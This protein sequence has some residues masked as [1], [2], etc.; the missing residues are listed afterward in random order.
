MKKILL[1]LFS[2]L[3]ISSAYSQE[4]EESIRFGLNLAGSINYN[5]VGYQD[6]L[7]KGHFIDEQVNDGGLIAPYL[8]V[9]GSYLSDDWW[10]IQLRVSYDSRNIFAIDNSFEPSPEFT[11][12][13][14]YLNIEPILV[15]NDFFVQDLNMFVGPQFAIRLDTKI[16]Y[17][18]MSPDDIKVSG[19]ELSG[20]NALAMGIMA[21]LDYDVVWDEL[22]D[23]TDIVIS[24]FF[25]FSYLFNQREGN[26]EGADQNSFDD[27]WTTSSFRVGARIGLDY[28][29]DDGLFW[30][31]DK[32]FDNLNLQ[33]PVEDIL[34]V[35][36]VEDHLPLVPH[37]FFNE[38]STAIP[39]RYVQLTK[40]QAED[41]NEEDFAKISN[42]KTA[43]E[44]GKTEEARKQLVTYYNLMNIYGERLRENDDVTVNL[45][46]SAPK[47]GDG[48]EMAENVK[49]YL[50]DVFDIDA[51]R[52]STEGRE[53]PRIKSG[54]DA[55][56]QRDRP[57]VDI[58]NRRVEFVFSDE[59]LNSEV[60]VKTLESTSPENDLVFTFGNYDNVRNWIVTLS[61]DEQDFSFGP[62]DEGYQ[63]LDPSFLLENADEGDYI[64]KVV[65]NKNTGQTVVEERKF[66]LR[67]EFSQRASKRY[68]ILFDYAQSDAV[69]SYEN[70]LKTNFAPMVLPD[71]KVVIQG[72]T[73]NTGNKSKN[74][75][76]S[77]DRANEVKTMLDTEFN[78]SGKVV[79]IQTYGFGENTMH[80]SFKNDLPEGRFYNRSVSLEIVP[81]K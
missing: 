6:F 31:Y 30:V 47:G 73:D 75:Q 17:D 15:Y 38:G 36:E 74:L 43:D 70:F 32:Q 16:D 57:L 54:T 51:D 72:H 53:F 27:I 18:P 81:V 48:S 8:G 29:L 77:K 69:Q 5:G 63:R 1:I 41:F 21:G 13:N 12:T 35:R 64:A 58:E 68:S 65:I 50:V 78:N 76:L 52:I 20:M 25:E 45:I 24:P 4:R 11:F 14:N 79:A 61:G 2:M 26:I 19:A 40:E 60:T 46:G 56:P 62:F 39:P 49:K 80:S 9:Y 34:W 7:G 67:K 44:E 23:N 10:G 55:T 59:K 37:V 22:N 28:K 3:F 66:R 71:E 33:T 42:E